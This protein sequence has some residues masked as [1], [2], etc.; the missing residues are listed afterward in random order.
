MDD[1]FWGKPLAGGLAGH[2]ILDE[3][4][5][6]RVFQ[7][8]V[9]RFD[10][11][12][13]TVTEQ[14]IDS[15][16]Q[17]LVTLTGPGTLAV[18]SW[19]MAAPP[20]FPSTIVYKTDA[21]SDSFSAV[22]TSGQY[23][24]DFGLWNSSANTGSISVNPS[25][26][27]QLTGTSGG[28]V[29]GT[30]EWDFTSTLLSAQVSPI[31]SPD[32]SNVVLNG[33]ELTQMY[34]ESLD[35]HGYYV[36]IGMSST[37]LYAQY[38]GPNGTLTQVIATAANYAAG[39]S[40]TFQYS[41]WQI[42]EAAGFFYFWTSPDG[43]T[44]TQVFKAQR[45][46]DS[47]RVGVYFASQYTGASESASVTSVNSDVT[48]SS[49]GGATYLNQPIMG[50]YLQTLAA[51][52]N[53][54]T[55]PFVQT[56]MNTAADSFGNPWADSQSVQ[57]G[58]GT[59]LFSLLQGHASMVD[60]DYIMEPGFQ[61]VV[62]LPA[63][64]TP[65]EGQVT[66]GYD[67]SSAVRFYEAERVT[68]KTRQRQ[69]NQIQNL[70]ATINSD[71]ITV[72]SDDPGSIATWGQREAWVQ[73]A[74][75]VTEA[76]LDVVASAAAQQFADEVFSWTIQVL[77]WAPGKTVFKD[78]GV[79]D[80]IGVER[81]DF[82]AVDVVR[83]TGITVAVTSA[84]DET[85]E[86]VL[87][88]Y[89]QWLEERLQYIATKMG[90][91]FVSASGTTAVS[92]NAQGST[93]QAPTV[94]SQSL[95]SLGIP[96]SSGGAP[97]VYNPV[98]GQWLPAGS[99]DP[100]TGNEVPLSVAGSG[101]TTVVGTTGVSVSA[102]VSASALNANPTFTGGTVT[103]WAGSSA[104]IAAV[105][106]SAGL[107][108]QASAARITPTAAG[109]VSLIRSS[110]PNAAVQGG[111]PYTLFAYAFMPAQAN[112][113]FTTEIAWYN[114]AGGVI[115]TDALTTLI[116]A[117]QWVQLAY[118]DTAP[119]SAVAAEVA[120]GPTAGVIA[121]PAQ[122]AAVSL[123]QGGTNAGTAASS[124]AV[125]PQGTVVTDS[126]G[127]V[128]IV[129]GLQGDG[130]T[131][132]NYYNGPS[133]NAPDTPTLAAG[134]LSLQVTWDGL[135]GGTAPLSDFLLVQVHVSTSSGF[136]P[137]SGTLFTTMAIAG[138]VAVAGLTAGTTY[139]VKLVAVNESLVTST[140]STQA[141]GVP[142]TVSSNIPAGS[143]IAVQLAG[144]VAGAHVTIAGTAPGSPATNDLWYDS[145]NGFRLNQWSGSA[146]VAVQYG[147]NAIA[148][149][150]VT[151]ALIAAN[152]ITAAQIA[153][154]TITALQITSAT[155]TTTQ[156]AANTIVAGNIAAGAITTT[157]IAA[158]TITA[159][160]IA[161][162]TITSAQ[163]HAATI[164]AGNIVSGTITATQIQSGTIT[165]TQIQSGTVVAGI[166]NGTTVT[167]AT[168]VADGASGEFLVYSGTPTTGNL[169]ASVSAQTGTDGHSNAYEAGIAIYGSNG[170]EV[171]L[172]VNGSAAVAEY[173]SGGA[174][175]A[176]PARTA[177]TIFNQG[178]GS[179]YIELRFAGPQSSFDSTGVN[180]IL[181]SSAANGAQLAT[182]VLEAG[183]NSSATWG[184]S[185]SSTYFAVTHQLLIGG[186]TSS[187]Q[188]A[189][190]GDVHIGGNL[191]TSE[192][193]G[194][195][196]PLAAVSTAASA[197]GGATP[198]ANFTAIQATYLNTVAGAVNGLISRLQSIGVL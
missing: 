193:N 110:T 152:T 180:I 15:S 97:L 67:R 148:A 170:S 190:S 23:I 125:T 179:E 93:M 141:S 41:Y 51:A 102:P 177:M 132:T 194:G 150:T 124:T 52:R 151:A 88:S 59:D 34:I 96:T 50:V 153:S 123:V 186:V 159:A 35:G 109:A 82:S 133:P 83:V 129:T 198:N 4:H 39:M 13:E 175:E 47:S 68:V 3:E 69:R 126:S 189:T 29:L 167:G 112:M 71:S 135:L 16:E 191:V 111:Q 121:N 99:T 192:F 174:S 30:T 27:A 26:S 119:A 155:I 144:G 146:W 5:L 87:E 72:T 117:S 114:A 43:Q 188:M 163:I 120:V 178:L 58:N 173:P 38:K 164:T 195:V 6:F 185:G 37:S 64:T 187:A 168:I 138:T 73:A 100:V 107:P 57:I 184:M 157:Q 19:A 105:T 33:S 20:G 91:G 142:T 77:P 40:A 70:I 9:P 85:H 89:V 80:W 94:F 166:V 116:P 162:G 10:F 143:I 65:N 56:R 113:G 98:T 158:T 55:I 53:R 149:G 130:T 104:A 176:A 32:A 165:A 134:L 44:W 11:L 103:G 171:H 48:T 78:F 197:P 86:L 101:G 61:L 54:G 92:G 42:S 147:T 7:E 74:A 140:P 45:E 156:L 24:I 81:P 106:P 139:Y 154:G 183:S 196:L 160:N 137:S 14:L 60:A 63:A 31:V 1:P 95:S 12:G 17:R 76:D 181:D 79:G 172:Y 84:G 118:Q 108:P 161:T 169:V 131:T 115:Q 25:G 21:L 127:N 36:M 22:N 128:R 145:G 62:G 90:G 66:I 18:L 182:G 2:Y 28:T 49:L 46:W 8:G 136:T 75:Q 122:V